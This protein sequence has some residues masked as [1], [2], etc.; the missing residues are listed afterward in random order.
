MFRHSDFKTPS[1]RHCHMSASACRLL[2]MRSIGLSQRITLLSGS[3]PEPSS[4]VAD[5]RLDGHLVAAVRGELL[6][7]VRNRPVPQ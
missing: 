2:N 4:K 6:H 1:Y 3:S 7:A 5:S